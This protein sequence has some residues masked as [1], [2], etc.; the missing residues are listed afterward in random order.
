MSVYYAFEYP[1]GRVQSVG[2]PNP[3]TGEQNINGLLFAFSTKEKRERFI[4]CETVASRRASITHK[5]VRSVHLG[6]SL[7]VF[8]DMLAKIDVL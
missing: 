4:Q 7:K 8:R 5:D 3:V 2:E 1:Q 6:M